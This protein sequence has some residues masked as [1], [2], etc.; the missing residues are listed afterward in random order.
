MSSIPYPPPLDSAPAKLNDAQR[1][2]VT[3]LKGPVLVL[4][5]AGTGKTRV[6]TARIARLIRMG[7]DPS[8]ICAVTFTNKAAREMRERVE[9]MVSA[10]AASLVTL[11]TFH[12]LCVRILRLGIHLLGFKQN[13]SIYDESDQLGLLRR[14][15]TRTAAGKEKLDP[16]AARSAISARKNMGL[17]ASGNEESLLG[18]VA[19]RYERE[20]QQL[21]AV[22]FD[23]LLLLAVRL[24]SEHP[25]E[26]DRWKNRFHHL[27][28]DEFQDT[29][30]LQLTLLKHLAR[31]EP[32][33]CVV[34]DDDQSIYG[35]RGAEIKNILEFERHFPSARVIKLE[36]NYR[37]TGNILRA[38]NS[39][40]RRNP[41]RHGKQLWSG[42]GDGEPIRVVAAPDEKEEAR[43]VVEEI[44]NIHVE[45][46][47]SWENF[48][49]LFRMNNQA[50]SFEE[51]LR[52]LKVPYRLV[53][54]R[55][56]FD[57][58]EIKDLS[59]WCNAILNPD[60]DVSLLRALT[61]PPRGLG[62]TTVGQALEAS[63]KKHCSV[64]AVLSDPT[65]RAGLNRRGQAAAE[66]FIEQLRE[67][68]V[69]VHQ[70]LIS[71]TAVMQDLL[72]AI[73]FEEHVKKISAKPE[74][75]DG[76]WES[77]RLF[78]AW[79]QEFEDKQNTQGA[80]SL[81]GF[82]DSLSLDRDKGEKEDSTEL[83]TL[84]TLHAAK[85]LEYPHVY[86]VG[87]EEGILPH[88]RSKQENR[89][90]EERRLLYVG[91][92]R[93]MKQ[94][95]ITRCDGRARHGQIL[96]SQPSSFLKDFDEGLIK[97]VSTVDLATESPT[98]ELTEFYFGNLRAKL[99]EKLKAQESSQT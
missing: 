87:F 90:E 69:R 15:I 28:V 34:G 61:A 76:R 98:E 21:N 91:I 14:I 4:A 82:L 84:I 9:N 26:R 7:E 94:L 45:K 20:L 75:F 32:N 55:S 39:V 11:S 3:S 86:L 31:P 65:F 33:L 62:E 79:M 35:W 59:A 24:L 12:S 43:F 60:D 5:G 42:E 25:V 95:T 66:E 17:S 1:D 78:L 83:V 13:F 38:A 29:N 49:I 51:E 85:G 72:V 97:E 18:A 22:D 8:S 53:G 80:S 50:R 99:E 23:D 44:R 54:A 68:Y 57:R 16:R 81:R 36:Q 52:R 96:P 71:A 19:L 74:E 2:A 63:I 40:I 58:R 27:M 88:S 93:A 64:H 10:D 77:V 46:G 67:F 48:A 47:F 56:F 92:T 30:S 89:V 37:S 6:I 70:P 41:E 73:S